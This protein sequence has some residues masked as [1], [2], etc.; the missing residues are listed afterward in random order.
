MGVGGSQVCV[1]GASLGAYSCL[2]NFGGGRQ[3]AHS[4]GQT[5]EQGAVTEHK[6]SGSFTWA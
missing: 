5:Q 3:R 2:P 4:D 6:V 1:G